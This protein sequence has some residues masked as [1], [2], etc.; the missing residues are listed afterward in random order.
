M[1]ADGQVVGVPVEGNGHR[2][3][4]GDVKKRG[5]GDEVEETLGGGAGDVDD[6][7]RLVSDFLRAKSETAWRKGM[8][9]NAIKLYRI[10]PEQLR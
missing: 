8:R 4:A 1:D 10:S 9:E 7:V 2:R 5:V 6:V 3:L